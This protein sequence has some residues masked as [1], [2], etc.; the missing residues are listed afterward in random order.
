MSHDA[1]IEASK[2]G[3]L[4]RVEELLSKGANPN[5]VSTTAL[6]E[7]P[8]HI[9]SY[10]G[11]FEIVKILLLYG[12]NPNLQDIRGMTSLYQAAIFGH[13]DI[14]KIL[15][16]NGA[17]PK[18]ANFSRITPLTI[19]AHGGHY[20]VTKI[21]RDYFPSLQN[22]SMRSIRTYGINTLE[23]PEDLYSSLT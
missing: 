9:S 16:S 7:I 5:I 23:V 2:Q 6:P 1:L 19:A 8:L 17:D 3:N 14:I 10:Y 15:L 12:A 18:I 22:L 20:T 11:H 4:R 13:L 21:L